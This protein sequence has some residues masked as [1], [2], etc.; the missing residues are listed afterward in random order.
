MFT[1]ILEILK[2]TVYKDKYFIIKKDDNFSYSIKAKNGLYGTIIVFDNI[3]FVDVFVKPQQFLT[4]YSTLLTP[5]S[6]SFEAAM[7]EN[8]KNN[9]L[10]K[11]QESLVDAMIRN[12][13]SFFR[14]NQ[15]TSVHPSELWVGTRFDGCYYPHILFSKKKVVKNINRYSFKAVSLNDLDT[16]I[17]QYY[18]VGDYLFAVSDLDRYL[19]LVID[20]SKF[21]DLVSFGVDNQLKDDIQL[22]NKYLN[23][24]NVLMLSRSSVSYCHIKREHG[25]LMIV[26]FD[27]FHDHSGKR[28][29]DP[30]FIRF[31]NILKHGN[32]FYKIAPMVSVTWHK[33][34]V[35]TQQS[36]FD[37]VLAKK[38][39]K[40]VSNMVKDCFNVLQLKHPS[41]TVFNA[42]SE[43]GLP[44]SLPL[45]RETLTV[46]D[47]YLI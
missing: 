5:D 12:N 30:S 32:Q 46:V 19:D 13:Y 18:M 8:I 44:D 2:P 37:Q 21:S 16:S 17:S 39:E 29:A 35:T 34:K 20:R 41:K 4:R 42:L 9:I 15:P 36:S 24:S 7:I 38:H 31:I 45:S 28:K 23:T 3:M 33:G 43:L 6:V 1:K 40:N 10:F 14:N 25:K 27:N 26:Y 11:I 47:M 22:Y